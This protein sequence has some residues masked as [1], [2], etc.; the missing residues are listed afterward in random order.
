MAIKYI[1][2]LML[3]ACLS[4]CATNPASKNNDFV[5]MSEKT[6]LALGLKLAAQYNQ[7][8]PLLDEKDPLA[9]FVNEVGQRVA[10]VADR[11]ELF[12]HFRVVDN[13]T[14]NAFALPGGHIYIHRG[15]L[16]HLNSEA[17]LAAVLGHE[18]GHVTAR[19][20]V[21]RYTQIQGYQLGMAIT[22]IFVPIRP[23]AS[24]LTNL[25]AASF[26]SGYGRDQELQADD[27]AIK[28]I[29]KAGYDPAA[30]I[31][32]L[33]TLKRLEEIDNKEKKDVGDKV[34]EY[35]GAFA[36]HPETKK[37]IAL[38]SQQARA[39]GNEGL[40]NHQRMLAA[41]NGY[42]YADNPEQGAVVGQRFLHPDLNLQLKFPKRWVIKNTPQAV[43]ARIRQKKVYF[44]LSIK[45]LSKRRTASKLLESI[46]PK[47]HIENLTSST[48]MGYPSAHARVKAS[49]PHVSQ[50][51]IDAT[52]WL[53]GS[54]AFLLFMW[55]PRNDVDQ[56]ES[57]FKSIRS[58]LKF[59]DEK[60]SGGIPRIA[61]HI[62]KKGDSWTSLARQSNQILGRFTA[63]RIAALNGMELTQQPKLGYIIKTVQ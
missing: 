32:L 55:A 61:L 38:A 52:V 9:V 49:A 33:A 1:L 8:L 46:F 5:L 35:H 36:S 14:I 57:D 21:Q 11:P 56:Y 23:G 34:N 30:V 19:H 53:K 45:P 39:S 20:A 42:P 25:L 18:I 48:V 2:F 54:Q 29:P 44:E 4:A 59:Y 37:R 51:Y 22:S 16:N 28:Y 7:Q 3:A 41:V 27:L 6:E 58:S 47:R 10:K 24:S 62:W 31:Q 40:I 17:E 26:I 12:Y 50:A 13:A 60:K 15:L 43:T 63:D